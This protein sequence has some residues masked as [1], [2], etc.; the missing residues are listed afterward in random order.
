VG[1]DQS[2]CGSTQLIE[3][4]P[5]FA[6]SFAEELLVRI[7]TEALDWVSSY[8][9]PGHVSMTRTAEVPYA[10]GSD[11]AVLV[12]PTVGV[13]CPMLIQWPDRYYHSSYDTPDRCSPASLALA[14]RIAATYAGTLATVHGQELIPL[15]ARGARRRLLAALELP[16]AE[17]AAARERLRGATALRS[18]ERLG[19]PPPRIDAELAAFQAFASAEAAA[20]GVPPVPERS[21]ALDSPELARVP[22]RLKRGPLDFLD[23]L[24]EGYE[25]LDATERERW[26]ALRRQGPDPRLE[27]AWFACDGARRVADIARLAD[28]ETSPADPSDLAAFFDVTAR[29]GISSWG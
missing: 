16:G 14:A 27:L 15:V 19:V 3:H 13:P 6:A 23:H 29:L 26:R 20:A 7:R 11:H 18:L 8:S 12:D 17:R 24:V 9:G 21:A 2:A 25:R 22:V 10:G 4:P 1:E 28:L 5:C